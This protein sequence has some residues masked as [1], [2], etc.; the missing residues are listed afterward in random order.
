MAG[1]NFTHAL[2][3]R[4]PHGFCPEEN[5]EEAKEQ[6]EEFVKLLRDLGLDVIELPPDPKLP[7][8]VYVEDTAVVINGTALIARLADES[9][10]QE[11]SFISIVAI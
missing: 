2:V 10:K 11:V 7:L 9:R 4:V 6:H 5:L 1:R 3:C 8:C